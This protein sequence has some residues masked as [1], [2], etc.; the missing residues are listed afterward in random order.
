[1]KS[2]SPF[3]S[4]KQRLI[5]CFGLCTGVAAREAQFG[6]GVEHNDTEGVG[7]A[8]SLTFFITPPVNSSSSRSFSWSVH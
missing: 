7:V 8:S 1:M 6:D 4:E 3:F 5:S 2:Y